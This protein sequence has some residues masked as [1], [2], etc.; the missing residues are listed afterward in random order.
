MVNQQWLDEFIKFDGDI[1]KIPE[2]LPG[3]VF[4]Q[5]NFFICE[6]GGITRKSMWSTTHQKTILNNLGKVIDNF[7][8]FKACDPENSFVVINGQSNQNSIKAQLI[9]FIETQQLTS[10]EF[11]K[12]NIVSDH[13]I[14]TSVQN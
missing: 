6:F 11:R 1:Q 12:L 5:V 14:S 9:S 13:F 2:E 10:Q 3:F 4:D 7:D 8:E